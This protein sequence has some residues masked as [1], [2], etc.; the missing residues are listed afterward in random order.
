[1]SAVRALGLIA[2]GS[3]LQESISALQERA[4]S[5]ESGAV[6]WAALKTIALL[7]G[8]DTGHSHKTSPEAF[9]IEVSECKRL[10]SAPPPISGAHLDVPALI[11]AAASLGGMLREWDAESICILLTTATSGRHPTLRSAACK[12]LGA[13]LSEIDSGVDE[14][15]GE[16]SRAM[17]RRLAMSCLVDPEAGVRRA[18]SK[19]ITSAYRK[20]GSPEM[21]KG[22]VK[23]I[24]SPN[25]RE[26]FGQTSELRA[27][28]AKGARSCALSAL[29]SVIP[30]E[31]DASI[32]R[33][34]L[35]EIARKSSCEGVEGDGI[36]GGIPEL[37][38]ALRLCMGGGW[39]QVLTSRHS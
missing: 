37:V 12:S 30:G 19:A 17:L 35:E 4:D 24:S 36:V 8:G 7:T 27:A 15:G 39:S 33:L 14:D 10:L 32:G 18:A 20:N 16:E 9:T 5:D 6:R 31:G 25:V 13:V 28:I 23:C 2:G 38:E 22:L 1:M 34:V 29:I 21:V 11:E 26:E 3:K